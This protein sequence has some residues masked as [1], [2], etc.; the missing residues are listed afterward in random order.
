M[1][2][3]CCAVIYPGSKTVLYLPQYAAEFLQG[4]RQSC[5]KPAVDYQKSRNGKNYWLC[6]EHWDQV[7]KQNNVVAFIKW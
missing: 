3:T 6:S 5:G 1:R 4:D 7:E 2:E